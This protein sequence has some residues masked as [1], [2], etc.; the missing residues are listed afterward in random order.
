M[1][2]R[3]RS[4]ADKKLIHS[5]DLKN[6]KIALKIYNKCVSD[7]MFHTMVGYNFLMELRHFIGK[8]GLVSEQSLAPIPIKEE[9]EKNRMLL[10]RHHEKEAKWKRLYE[11]QQLLNKKLKLPFCGSCSFDWFCRNKFSI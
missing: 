1:N 7:K 2:R 8:S 11:G 3:K 9:N 10:L 4:R 6:L 5:A